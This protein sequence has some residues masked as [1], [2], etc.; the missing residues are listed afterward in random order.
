MK[1]YFL[2][3]KLKLTQGPAKPSR[4]VAF[5]GKCSLETS[6]LWFLS[7]LFTTGWTTGGGYSEVSL[8]RKP[9]AQ[10]VQRGGWGRKEGC[11]AEDGAGSSIIKRTYGRLP[12]ESSL[13]FSNHRK[14]HQWQWQCRSTHSLKLHQIPCTQHACAC[15]CTQSWYDKAVWMV[16][17]SL[18]LTSISL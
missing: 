5:S 8:S 9:H 3:F 18:S 11:R 4:H 10:R 14:S 6:P 1:V 13:Q 2:W 12:T 17:V 16:A 15:S 7:W